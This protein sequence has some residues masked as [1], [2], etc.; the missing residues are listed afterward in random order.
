METGFLWPSHFGWSRHHPLDRF[1]IEHTKLTS[2]YQPRRST[3]HRTIARHNCFDAKG[4]ALFCIFFIQIYHYI[5]FQTVPPYTR[6]F[7]SVPVLSL[8]LLHFGN[9]WGL[10]FLVT[11][12][13]QY[14][15][16]ALDFNMKKAGILSSLPHLARFLAGFVFGWIGDCLRRKHLS[17]TLMR[18]SFCIFC[19]TESFKCLVFIL[20]I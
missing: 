7:K 2:I 11:I 8:T 4:K 14:M 16:E 3:I 9:T 20:K 15:S 12:A 1:C 5:Y 6:M 18:K 17:Q 10:F 19:K 13:P